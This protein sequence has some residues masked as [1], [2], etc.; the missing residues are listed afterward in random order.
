LISFIFIFAGILLLPHRHP[1]CHPF[2]AVEEYAHGGQQRA[3]NYI[4]FGSCAWLYFDAF[5]ILSNEDF[6]ALKIWC[7]YIHSF[8]LHAHYILFIHHS[9]PIIHHIL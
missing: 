7:V 4:R 1:D 6:L 5:F 9:E 2:A 3:T 8:I